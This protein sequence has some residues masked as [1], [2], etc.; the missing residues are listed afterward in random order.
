MSN[1]VAKVFEDFTRGG[2]F[3]TL[4]NIVA[5]AISAVAVLILARFLGPEL[6]GLYSISTVIPF[7]LIWLTDLGINQGITK[8]AATLKAKGEEP[9]AVKLLLHGLSFKIVLGLAA[10][11]V[12]FFFSDLLAEQI[13]RRPEVGPYVQMA[14]I[15]IILHVVLT[16]VNSAFV[17]LDKTLHNALVSDTEAGVKTIISLTLVIQGFGVIGALSGYVGGYI[18]ADLVALLLLFKIFR[19]STRHSDGQ[20]INFQTSSTLLVRYGFPLYLSALIMG[21]TGQYQNILLAIFTSNEEIGNYRAALN[22]TSLVGIFSVP[23]ATA[24]V[25]AFSKI[26]QE[27]EASKRFFRLSVRYTS[28][29]ILPIV[30]LMTLYSNEIVR[31]I[32]GETY[33]SAAFFVSLSVF[34][35]YLVGLGSLVL[36]SFFSA[37]G[38]TKTNLKVSLASSSALLVSAPILTGFFKIP[39]MIIS[40]AISALIS[41]IYGFS[42][43]KSKFKVKIEMGKTVRIYLASLAPVIPLMALQRYLPPIGL[44]QVMFGVLAYIAM[45]LFI[46]PLAKTITRDELESMKTIL[47]KTRPLKILTKPFFY[48]EEKIMSLML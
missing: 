24:L 39:G 47:Y 5:T 21:F 43:A 11:G 36:T 25:P 8:Y 14:S 23:V 13:L 33:T 15:L 18:A 22:F 31:I 2:F 32:Y 4:G 42:L 30:T 26:E 41:T 27:G 7:L 12:C 17:G 44:Y 6:Y 29:A 16:T 10:T 3:L 38:E 40:F 37:L 48:C 20:T 45:Y 46:T 35:F 9:R 19:S 1:N 34:Q 28:M